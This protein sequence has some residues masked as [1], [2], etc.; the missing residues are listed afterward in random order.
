MVR[1][2]LHCDCPQVF[3]IACVLASYS[4]ALIWSPPSSPYSAGEIRKAL[5]ILIVQPHGSGVISEACVV[6]CA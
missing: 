6:F 3:G 2:S 1:L 5:P 4:F